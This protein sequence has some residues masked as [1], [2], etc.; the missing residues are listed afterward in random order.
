MVLRLILVCLIG[1]GMGAGWLVGGA[2][3][4][5]ILD[6]DRSTSEVEL[7]PEPNCDGYGRCQIDIP[8]LEPTGDLP[9]RQGQG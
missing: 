2:T 1:L 7:V 5:A 6:V 4:R 9:S 3:A 8:G